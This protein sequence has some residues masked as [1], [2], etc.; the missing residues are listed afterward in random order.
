MVPTEEPRIEAEGGQYDV[1]SIAGPDLSDVYDC[2][3]AAPTQDDPADPRGSV[4]ADDDEGA[5]TE[6]TFDASSLEF[7]I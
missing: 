6:N 5:D 4:S 1:A 2:D 7:D 3:W